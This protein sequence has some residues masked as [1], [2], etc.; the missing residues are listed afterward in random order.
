[1][2]PHKA[3][4]MCLKHY[5]F[6]IG[7]GECNLIPNKYKKAETFVCQIYEKN[8]VDSE[9]AAHRVIFQKGSKP[10]MM[11]PTK[12]AL[13]LHMQ[14]EHHQCSMW[15][16]AH[17]TVPQLP[18]VTEMEWTWDSRLHLILVTLDPIPEAC[19]ELVSCSS[20][21]CKTRC[22]TMHCS[23]HIANVSCTPAC[24]W[25]LSSNSTASSDWCFSDIKRIGWHFCH[26]F[27]H[28]VWI[29]GNIC[30]A[31]WQCMTLFDM[32]WYAMSYKVLMFRYLTILAIISI[33]KW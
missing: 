2:R 19:I 28:I 4:N 17:Y 16:L 25:R 7:L 15:N 13:G 5:Q 20:C 12:D 18:N 29:I 8:N 23:R 3:A 26:N 24:G 9:D 14:H 33:T 10:E 1:M 11:P 21:S 31:V 30:T 6:I 27:A 32:P 22:L